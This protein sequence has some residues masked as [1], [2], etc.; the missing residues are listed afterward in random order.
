[1]SA[2]LG[3]T[4]DPLGLSLVCDKRKMVRDLL[5]VRLMIE[6][7]ESV[8]VSQVDRNMRPIPGTEKEYACDTLILSVGLIPENELSLGAGVVLDERSREPW[9]MNI[10]RPAWRESLPPVMFSRSTTL[11]I[12]YPWRRRVWRMAWSG[13]SGQAICL[14]SP[15]DK[16]RR[17]GGSSRCAGAGERC[18]GD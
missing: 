18:G 5:Q 17:T 3:L 13:I 14:L 12:S 6:P 8:A 7:L 9:W 1:M 10:T 15:G 16:D 2:K 11:W 4:E